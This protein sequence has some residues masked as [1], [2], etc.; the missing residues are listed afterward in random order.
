MTF[1]TKNITNRMKSYTKKQFFD[2]ITRAKRKCEI[3]AEEKLFDKSG[4]NGAKFSLA[5][6]FEGWKEKQEIEHS[7]TVKLEDVL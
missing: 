3:Y 6:N 5:N 7:G 1:H 2:T 4:V